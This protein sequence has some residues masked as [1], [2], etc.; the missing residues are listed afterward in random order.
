MTFKE[1]FGISTEIG[2]RK[3]KEIDLL[4]LEGKEIT[5][6]FEV[7]TSINTAR[8][9][10]NDR[11]RDLYSL[12]PNTNIRTFVVV[13]DEDYKKAFDMINSDANKQSGLSKKVKI[14]K[15]S[16]L[17]KSNFAKWLKN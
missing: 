13:K 11:Y 9:A 8:E 7:T 3:I 2:F 15:R 4:I 17:I 10:I 16:N 5:A 12:L 1:D 14:I 6:A